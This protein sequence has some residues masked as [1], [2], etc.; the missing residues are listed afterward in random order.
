MAYLSCL[1]LAAACLGAL[2]RRFRLFL[3]RTP[4]AAALVLAAGVVFFLAWDAAGIA[5]GVF[6]HAPTPLA[7]GLMLA[8]ELPLEE[9]FFLAFFCY[10]AMLLFAG[11]ERVFA[12]RR[13]S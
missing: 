13:G 2:D 8:P 10:T 9:P 7:T 11:A 6:E 3:W 12:G 1:L 5:A 4:R